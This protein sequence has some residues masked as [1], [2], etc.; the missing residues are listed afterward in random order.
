M[1]RGGTSSRVNLG[2]LESKNNS[3]CFF[4][5]YQLFASFKLL[6]VFVTFLTVNRLLVGAFGRGPWEQA[7]G[8]DVGQSISKPS[9][10]LLKFELGTPE[11]GRSTALQLFSAIERR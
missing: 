4:G 3:Y 8:S 6:T 1:I 9:I 11:K 2:Y 5:D 7:P 10:S